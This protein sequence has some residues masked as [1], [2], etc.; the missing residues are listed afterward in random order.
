MRLIGRLNNKKETIKAYVLGLHNRIILMLLKDGHN[1]KETKTLAKWQ[2]AVETA[3][4]KRQGKVGQE[5]TAEKTKSVRLPLQKLKELKV[6]EQMKKLMKVDRRKIIEE[7]AIKY[8]D[9]KELI[10]VIKRLEINTMVITKCKALEIPVDVIAYNAEEVVI[11]LINSGATDNFIDFRTVAKLRLGTRKLPRPRQLFNVDGTH[12]QASLI[13]ESVHLYIE[14]GGEC[15][16]TQ[17]HITNLGRDRIIFGYPWLEAFNPNINW[18]EGKLLGPQTKL[19]TTRAVAQEHVGE[20]YEI[21]RMAMQARK[22]TIAQRMAENFQTNTL[23]PPEYRRH[24]K[25]FLE[26]E[27]ERFPPSRAWDHWI[28][29]KDDAPDTINEKVYNLPKPSKLAVE[30]WVYKMLEKKFI[31]RPDS[32]YG[33]ATFTVPKKDGTFRVVQDYRPVNKY[34]WKDMTPLPSI[35]DAIKSLGD[36]VLFSKFDIREGYNN[37]QLVPEDRWKA[38][39]KTHI[40]LFEPT[41]MMFRLQGAP[42]TFSRMI[43][44][45]I[46]PMYRESPLNWFKH[47]MDDCLVAMADSELML[48]HRM[49]HCLLDIF[50]EHLYFLKPSKCEFERTEIDFVGVRLGNGQITINPSKIAGIKE[51]PRTLK[52]VKE[53]R[54]TLGILGFQWPFIPGFAHIAKPLTG[55][56]KKDST[57]NW[58]PECTQALDRLIHIVTSK[59]VLVPPDMERQFILEVDTLQYATGAILFQADRK[60]KDQQGNPILCP[61][62]YH[63]QTFSATEQ[64]YPIY[65]RE[66]LAIIRGLKHWDYLLKGAAHPVLVITNH[67]NLQFHQHVH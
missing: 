58:T 53:V 34:T 30:D 7:M 21:K 41:A 23:I 59:P 36:K 52:S 24:V 14:R 17:F 49:N 56:L 50:E 4:A 25:V 46:A 43:A 67:A 32:R 22:T 64:W 10:S 9:G 8:L 29:L 66:F 31:Q 6:W 61:Y 20:A 33:H 37:I 60:L 62:G 19:K 47:Y 5:S 65:D 26:K 2:Q 40:R 13:G 28:P 1:F 12:N 45:D 55:L 15:T 38:A 57:F 51:W 18:K 27:V 39:F 16:R 42:G 63:S 35:Q 44:V 3:V 48:H 11:A 54:S